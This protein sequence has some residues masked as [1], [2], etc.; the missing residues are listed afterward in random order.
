MSE[1]ESISGFSFAKLSHS[2]GFNVSEPRLTKNV[3]LPS[4]ESLLQQEN[5]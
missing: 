1:K 3:R 5:N 2:S 4:D